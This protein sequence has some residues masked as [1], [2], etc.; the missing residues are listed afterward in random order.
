MDGYEVKKVMDQ[1][2]ISENMQE[3][4]IMNIQKRTESGHRQR[5]EWK[6]RR[7]A[8]TAAVFI[9]A[10]GM[11]GFPVRAV[12]SSVVKE[13]MESVPEAEMKG[14]NDMVQS[15]SIA[16]DGFSREYTDSEKERK[17][18]L[19]QA[20]ENGTFPEKVIAQV[21]DA[22]DALEGTL[23]YIRSTGYFNLPAQEMTDE[24]LLEI[25]DF[26]HKMSYAVAQ[27]PQAQAA[28][29]ESQE[30]EARLK[31]T[32]QD[33]GGISEDEAVE[34]AKKQ[35]ITDLGD[36]ADELELMMYADGTPGVSLLDA[37][38]YTETAFES[39]SKAGV[40]YEVGFG[41]PDTH[42]TYGYLIDAVDG[43]ILYT[44]Y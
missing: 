44:Y 18:A 11:I 30:K 9:A 36:K 39:E 40:V 42:A 1:I 29:A 7:M 35:L 20:Y 22:K 3:E 16:A 24:E 19:W 31:K 6:V 28:R 43:S 37:S 5:K 41:N 23:C 12:V 26:Q 10:A 2:H 33:A 4:I 8:A 14:L 34:I 21:E 27:G 38:D 32:L 15:Q 13:R 17:K 25:I